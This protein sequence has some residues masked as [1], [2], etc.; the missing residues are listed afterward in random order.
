MEEFEKQTTLQKFKWQASKMSTD[1]QRRGPPPNKHSL[2]AE[3]DQEEW[4]NQIL[5]KVLNTDALKP[6]PFQALTL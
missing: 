2:M 6:Q 1:P 5:A 3:D 4:P